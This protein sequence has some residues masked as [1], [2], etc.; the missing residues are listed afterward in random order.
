MPDLVRPSAGPARPIAVGVALA[1]VARER[2]VVF[3]TERGQE[4]PVAAFENE[5][6]ACADLL[7]RVGRDRFTLS[8]LIVGPAPQAEADHV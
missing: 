8:R 3:H 2:W 5:A 6:D 4:T 1:P 7:S